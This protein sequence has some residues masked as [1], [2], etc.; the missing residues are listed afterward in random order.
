MPLVAQSV[1]S[2]REIGASLENVLLVDDSLQSLLALEAILEGPDRR[3]IRATSGEEAL[4]R[5]LD[6]RL[7]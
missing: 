3:L 5:L 2:C 7:P 6:S 1:S 4:K